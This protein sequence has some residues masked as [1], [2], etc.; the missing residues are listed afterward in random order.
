MTSKTVSMTR[1]EYDRMVE[2]V[3]ALRAE[4]TTQ[5]GEIKRLTDLA[6]E[7]GNRADAAEE[8]VQRLRGLS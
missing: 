6:W 5:Y 8:E 1:V 4:L 2:G 3:I 7:A